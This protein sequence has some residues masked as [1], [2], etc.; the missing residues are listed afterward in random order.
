MPPLISEKPQAVTDKLRV[1]SKK[2]PIPNLQAPKKLQAQKPTC[3]P[4]ARASDFEV[5]CL[6]FGASLVLGASL[7]GGSKTEIR[8]PVPNQ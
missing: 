2:L 5:W 6:R 8:E 4:F 7:S 3:A 1:P